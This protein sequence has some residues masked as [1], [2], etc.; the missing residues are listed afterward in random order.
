MPERDLYDILGVPRAATADEIKK[1]YRR[2]AKKYHPDVNPGDKA[3]EERFKEVTAAAEV[4]SDPKKRAFY[5]EFG[6]DSLRSGFDASKADAYRQ[7]KRQGA[8]P[9][10][11]P[12][13]FGGF[14]EVNVGDFGTF[15]FG[16]VF[17]DLFGGRTGRGRARAAQAQHGAHA[18]AEISVDLRDA[19][20]GAERDVRVGG[21]TLRVKI[22]KGVAD[23]SSVR[24]SGQGAPGRHGGKA[25]DLYLRVKLR[26]HP[27]I[28]RDGKDLY[29]DLP[30]T[31]PEAVLGGEVML[32][33]FEGPVRL[34]IPPGTQS[35]KKLRLRGKGMPD[36]RGGDRGDLY[37]T[38]RIV[39]PE[40]S[41]GL[42]KAVKPLEDL[43]K[44]DPRAEISL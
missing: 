6:A 36:L 24:L 44:A 14:Q 25:G 34:Q 17:E 2:L 42:E 35:G 21:K 40:R 10:G 32:P 1:A 5:D 33:T 12:F 29:L 8:P 19:V 7:W 28:H 11:M 38:V 22:P 26:E 4:L 31:V 16:S 30:V 18:E 9:G 41:A 23:G 39:L 3:S 20:L 27:W 37:A 43:Y 13:D 15:D